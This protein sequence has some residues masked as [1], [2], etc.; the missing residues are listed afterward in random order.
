MIYFYRLDVIARDHGE[1]RRESSALIEIS[2]LDVNDN[3]PVFEHDSYNVTIAED[4]QT[5]LLI[6]TVQAT[7][8]DADTNGQKISFY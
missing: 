5:P 4:V 6:S 7:D 1:P 2:I 3:A 8:K